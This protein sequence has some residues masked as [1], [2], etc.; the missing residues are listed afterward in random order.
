MPNG[1][2]D[3]CGTCWFNR[4]N[5]GEKGYS[6]ARDNDVEPYCE[7]RHVLI[8]NPFWT[9]CANHPHRRPNRDPIPIGP[10]TRH[11][12]GG[13]SNDR[14][15]WIASPDTE[16]IRQHLLE[17]LENFFKHVSESRYPIGPDIGQV[18]VRQLGEFG[19][20]RAE[21]RIRWI[22]E[23]CPSPWADMASTALISISGEDEYA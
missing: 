4:K 11:S 18:V 20:K 8:E 10:L 21:K 15:M 7:I 22:S 14:E 17:L 5:G 19:E 16:E 9:Y 12:G 1:G 13:S 3:C 23:N 6:Q 2:S